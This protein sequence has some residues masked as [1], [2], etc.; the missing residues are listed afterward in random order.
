MDHFEDQY[1]G[2]AAEPL[3]IPFDDDTAFFHPEEQ[4]TE[5]PQAA[6]SRRIDLHGRSCSRLSPRNGRC[7]ASHPGRRSHPRPQDGARQAADAEVD[8]PV[9]AGPAIVVEIA[10]NIKR[11]APGSR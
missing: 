11:E 10:E 2:D 3:G 7:P 1:I 5:D 9:A 8:Q 4:D 6:T